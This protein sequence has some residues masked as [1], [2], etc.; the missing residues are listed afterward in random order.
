MKQRI[1]L[2]LLSLPMFGMA[3]QDSVVIRTMMNQVLSQGKCY[4]RLDYL[5]NKI[6]PRL[7]GSVGAERAVEW[8]KKELETE[9][10]D[11]VWLQPVMVPHWVRGDKEKAWFGNKNQEAR[12]CALG[13]SVGTGKAGLEAEVI[14]V[15][16]LKDLET[17]GEKKVKGKIVFFNRPMNPLFIHTFEAYGDAVDQRGSGAIEA[18]KYGAVGVVVRSMASN[19][20]PYPHTGA[21]RYADNVPKIPACAIS[22]ADAEVLSQTLR[23]NSATRF[24]FR[25]TCEMLPDV[26]SFNVIAEIRG[27][28]LP[29]E[30]VVVGGHLDCWDN[31]SG[32]HD[33]GAGCV[34]SM[35]VL[36]LF[37]KTGIRPSRTIRCV[38]FMNEENGLRGGI[39]YA[40]YAAQSGEK[41]VAAIETDAG[42]FTPRYFNVN[43][44]DTVYN[45][46]QA[47]LPFLRPYGIGEII[48][49]GGGADISP[50]KKQGVTLI[51]YGPDSQRY[52]DLH[53]SSADTFDK[54]SKREL[55]LGAGV[56]AGMVW[57]ISE[58][59]L[60]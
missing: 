5:A 55:E 45:R 3:Q 60:E 27:S 6:G 50:L 1:L 18:A 15:K 23:S 2:F 39:A 47:F 7:S 42:G 49:G 56:L 52:F 44:D 19:I 28:R 38:L 40:A 14:E 46:M 25:Q 30:V 13:N 33:D 22:T 58:K 17:L 51:G 8:A 26:P 12:I 4:P 36:R 41:H 37:R 59:G 16:Y 11:S 57:L 35:E 20:D 24:Y 43:A 34:Q 48:R 10:F 32:A 9:G 53:H 29:K 54:V 31:G 21:M